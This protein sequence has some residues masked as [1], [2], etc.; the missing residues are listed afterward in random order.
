[1]SLGLRRLL[2]PLSSRGEGASS[3]GERRERRGKRGAVPGGVGGVGKRS[4]LGSGLLFV[5]DVEGFQRLVSED[6]ELAKA[7][8]IWEES[9]MK[10]V[11]Q[12]RP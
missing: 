7:F 9:M 4:K 2:M 12:V 3:G 1:L 10:I 6:E 11:A 8:R 5:D